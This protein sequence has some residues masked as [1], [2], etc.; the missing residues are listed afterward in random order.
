MSW[1][2]KLFVGGNPIKDAGDSLDKLFTSD[3][4]RM[5]A[6]AALA[7]LEAD[8]ETALQAQ[9]TERWKADMASDSWLSKNIRPG[10][11]GLLTALLVTA[12]TASPWKALPDS[13]WT[14]LTTAWVTITGLYVPAREVGKAIVN[15][16]KK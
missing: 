15:W 11:W 14:L 8:L 12:I 9:F 1:L 6:H 7:K 5:Q 13:A 3:E 10:T 16:Q 4:E 2:S